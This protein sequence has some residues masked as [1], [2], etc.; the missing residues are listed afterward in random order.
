MGVSWREAK[1]SDKK[2]LFEEWWEQCK[3]TRTMPQHLAEFRWLFDKVAYAEPL[4]ILEIGTEKGGTL[5]FWS[6][7]LCV[8]EDSVLVSVDLGDPHTILD[9]ES[10]PKQPIVIHGNSHDPKVLAQV[11]KYQPFDFLLIDGDH[12]YAGVKADYKDYSPLVK[13]GGLIAFHDIG[14]VGSVRR[15]WRQLRGNKQEMCKL[16]GMGLITK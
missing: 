12:S 14:L 1:V 13:P 4:R 5:F 8:V 6:Q 9:L 11:V 3:R 7:L 15:F 16:M 10:F 2:Y